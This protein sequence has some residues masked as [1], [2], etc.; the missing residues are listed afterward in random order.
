M[1]MSVDD[2]GP[3]KPAQTVTDADAGGAKPLSD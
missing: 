1:V 3:L 2:I